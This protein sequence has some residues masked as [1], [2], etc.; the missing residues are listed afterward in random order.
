MDDD[1]GIVVARISR[2]QNLRHL[3]QP[4]ASRPTDDT[5]DKHYHLSVIRFTM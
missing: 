4:D 1:D 3:L 5:G 2:A